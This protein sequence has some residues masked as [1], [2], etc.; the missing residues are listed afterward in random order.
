MSDK[1]PGFDDTTD[2]PPA[3]CKIITAATVAEGLLQE[4]RTSLQKLDRAPLLVGFLANS[5]PA[6]KM[7]ANWTEKTCKQKYVPNPLLCSAGEADVRCGG[8]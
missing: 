3:T 2:P 1:N 5:D 8:G 7:Y 4:V 6:A